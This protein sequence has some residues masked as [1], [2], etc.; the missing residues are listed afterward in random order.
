MYFKFDLS[1]YMFAI[2]LWIGRMVKVPKKVNKDKFS[3]MEVVARNGA[4][5]PVI[6]H[7]DLP[8]QKLT[9]EKMVTATTNH[10]ARASHID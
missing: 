10:N 3:E 6:Y 8:D 5:W 4:I 7:I 9:I 2:T 1:F